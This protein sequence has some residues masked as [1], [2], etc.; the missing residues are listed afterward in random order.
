[1]PYFIYLNEYFLL[2]H[3]GVLRRYVK[4]Y[5][6]FVDISLKCLLGYDYATDLEFITK[7]D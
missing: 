2:I 5:I 1:M 4:A 6:G 7:E 3:T